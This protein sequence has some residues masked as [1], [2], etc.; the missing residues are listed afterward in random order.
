MGQSRTLTACNEAL[1]VEQVQREI[2]RLTEIAKNHNGTAGSI[3][4]Y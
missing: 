2:T 1:K 3:K 4:R